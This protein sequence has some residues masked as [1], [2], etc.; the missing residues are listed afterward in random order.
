MKGRQTTHT[1][2]V[3]KKKTAKVR[4]DDT[5]P[6][7]S[8]RLLTI[9]REVNVCGACKRKEKNETE[10]P[11]YARHYA[12]CFANIL[13][14][15]SYNCI[16]SQILSKEMEDLRS[17]SN[18]LHFTQLIR[19]RAGTPPEDARLIFCNNSNNCTSYLKF[20]SL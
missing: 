2:Y 17:A 18:F 5:H 6:K 8:E 4:K 12:R 10:N 19:R 11:L 13:L 7:Q 3:F 16:I 15:H 14:F 1:L 20:C 9:R